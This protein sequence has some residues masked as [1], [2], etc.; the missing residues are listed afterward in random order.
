MKA[1]HLSATFISL[2]PLV[3]FLGGLATAQ[4]TTIPFNVGVI[5][6]LDKWV[7]R[8]GL[9]C[10]SM[11]V[12]DFYATNN[13]YKT[14][15]VIHARDSK[16]D[17]VG[18]ASMALDLLKNTQVQAIIGPQTS[19]EANF[20]I[21]LGNRTQVPIVSFSAT[22][23]SLSSA[24]TPYFV[25]T[26]LNDSSQVKA[27]AAIFQAFG[28]K[29]AVPIYEDTNYGNGIVPFLT[30]AFQQI[31]TRVPYRSAIP[32]FASEDQILAQPYKLKTMQTRVF[33]VHMTPSIG[34]RFFLMAKVAEMMT[35]EYV[36]ILTDGLTNLLDSMDPSV[37][38]S[39]QGVLGIRPYVPKSKELENFKVRWKK[40]FQQDS[41]L[42]S[43][44]DI[45]GLWAYDTAKALA[46]AAEKVGGEN[47]SYQQIQFSE[48]ST[49]L[50]TLGVSQIGPK[51]LQ[52]ILKTE[53][54]GLSGEFRLVDGQLQSSAF[55][56]LNVIG[57]GWKE[58]GFWTPRNGILREMNVTSTQVYSTSKGNL[59]TII[60]PGDTTA[61]PKG[62]VIPTS[63]KKLR[64][65]VPV[66]DGFSEFVK[67]TRDSHTNQTIFT[68]YCID[69]FKAVMEAL[70]YAVPYEFVPFEKADDKSV[71]SYDNLTYQVYLQ[72]Y[73]AVVGDTTII[74]NRS[75]YVDF[76]LP[77]TESGVS[78][79]VPVKK[80]D[81]KN[82]WIFLT[83]LSRDLWL[84][85][86]AFF[87]FTGFV[88]WVLEHRVSDDFRGSI[89][90]QIGVTLW[91]SF[92][93]LVFAHRE[94]VAS[95][96]A[97][98]VAIIW[99]FVVLILSS[100]YTASLASM[101]TVQK[102][103][104]TITD[105]Q[106]LIKSGKNVGY[107][108]GSF[109]VGFLKKMGFDES[110]LKVYNSVEECND[111]LTKGSHNGGFD[112]VYDEIPY[113]KLI[114]S[115]YCSKYTM[116][117]PTYKTDGFGFVYPRGSP[118]VA[119]VS[120][121]VLNV[122]EGDKLA[123]IEQA[124]FGKQ[125]YFLPMNSFWGLFL[126]T[127]VASVSALVIF[128]I[129]F[130][131]RNRH[132]VVNLVI[133][134]RRFDE[135]ETSSATS[136][137]CCCCK[138]QNEVG[139]VRAKPQPDNNNVPQS[140]SVISNRI[141]GNCTPPPDEEGRPSTELVNAIPNVSLSQEMTYFI[142]LSNERMEPS[143]RPEMTGGRS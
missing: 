99:V 45:F 95:N 49:D 6:D 27:I 126:I 3:V 121:A 17:V 106:E 111:G 124:W 94:R 59:R 74:A 12:N 133:M 11:A 110:K 127:G 105:V 83:P 63:G 87:I 42:M 91:F 137:S 143:T 114:L 80:D 41:P 26:A 7:G 56:I 139:G 31:D 21:D 120:R 19:A 34:S 33:V 141:D 88:V 113:I 57:N 72:Q 48:N 61:I 65:G 109:V 60:W 132:L 44:L 50:A 24:E 142:E 16:N 8:M 102:L 86:G 107:Q 4:N 62:W 81:K 28:W 98:F 32:P 20:V 129:T 71:G 55:Q 118:L 64:V 89:G 70:P 92:S 18:A 75:L 108:D 10:I 40:K 131:C 125:T 122:T 85:S 140:P 35:D 90:D 130:Y 5:L 25:R 84:I 68:G 2:F 123:Q 104:P 77:Y 135:K 76:T 51:L 30:D 73:D 128:S 38:D 14:R 116:V 82:A 67:V 117:G 36:W 13:D 22:S 43:N 15:L 23:P 66:K 115:S 97:R 29:E 1:I 58:V 9:R 69:V 53:F 112:A 78:M 119:D 138:D 96:L 103:Q 93:T 136:M 46:M 52:T 79:I 37:I 134:A 39:M 47:S 100:S 101:L 54:R